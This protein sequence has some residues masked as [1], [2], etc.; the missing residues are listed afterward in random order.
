MLQLRGVRSKLLVNLCTFSSATQTRTQPRHMTAS[1]TQGDCDLSTQTFPLR[2]STSSWGKY[3]P[4]Q[5]L[6]LPRC[7]CVHVTLLSDSNRILFHRSVNKCNQTSHIWAEPHHKWSWIQFVSSV[8]R[9][10][11]CQNESHLSFYF[12]F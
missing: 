7:L 4:L 6:H 8:W 2:V 3:L 9:S 1:V 5:L 12:H 11:R 10:G